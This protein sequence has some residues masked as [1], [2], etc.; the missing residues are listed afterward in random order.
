LVHV[1]LA[2]GVP[3][4]RAGGDPRD[5]RVILWW[6]D[7]PLGQIDVSASGLPPRALADRIAHAIAGP[8]ADRLGPAAGSAPARE[9]QLLDRLD[10]LPRPQA[11]R[12][13][14]AI[15]T[16]DRPQELER[17][18][19][20]IAAAE[21]QPQEVVVIDNGRDAATR[22]VVEA[23]PSVRYVSESRPG[24][25]VARNTAVS[26]TSAPIVV[27]VDDDAVVHPHWLA[28]LTA[29]FTDSSV[30]AVTGLVLPTELDTEAQFVFESLLGGLGNGFRPR[31]YDPAFLKGATAPPVWTIG[32]GCNMAIR[33]AALELAGGF[34]ERLGAGASGCSEDSE[35]WYRFLGEGWSCVYEPWSLVFHQHRR[36]AAALRRQARAYWRGHV[37]ALLIQFARWR[38]PSNLLRAWVRLPIS[39]ARQAGLD[40]ASRLLAAARLTPATPQRP[41]RAQCQGYLRGALE[42]RMAGRPPQPRHKAALGAFLRRNPFPRPLTEGFFYREKMRALHRVAPDL[43]F[44]RIL[45]I[46]GGRSG[47]AGMLYP[48]AGIT[49]LDRDPSHADAPANAG[50]R[51]SFTVGDATALPFPDATFDAVTLF[52]VLEH[53]PDDRAAA[54][55]AMRVLRPGG[56]VLVSSPNLRWRS[57]YHP[58]MRPIC[59]TSADM[60]ARWEHARVGYD[61]AALEAL[62]GLPAASSADFITPVTVIGHDL[63]F[64]RLPDRLR[65]GAL[66]LLAPVT[67]AGYLLQPRHGPGTETAMSWRKPAP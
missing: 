6:R 36:D 52:D 40:A 43:P 5:V 31:R 58:L 22:R 19:T 4:V 14:L 51:I 33:R 8:L 1:D 67:W 63:A 29:P 44:E 55:E 27:F 66:L 34:D 12:V 11:A 21:D 13:S 30:M 15:C 9:L 39:L 32:A 48:A 54:A 64:S 57:P 50:P 7:R 17:C 46:G 62:F 60:M 49:N 56:W 35:L 38:H 24:L 3:D 26:V 65:R 23:F 41:T 10:G 42:I 37:T 20:S 18:L 59:P 16:R 61:R 47:L 28:W 53:I 2:E 25:S 45:E